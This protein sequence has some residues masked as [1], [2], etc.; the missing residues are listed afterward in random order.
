MRI[1][2]YQI[3]SPGCV[4]SLMLPP[5]AQILS[6]GV[7]SSAIHV[8]ILLDPDVPVTETRHFSI[9]GTGWDVNRGEL[10]DFVG[11]VHDGEFVWHVFAK[12]GEGQ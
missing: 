4:T 3:S 9:I 5:D 2:K 8:W 7:Q 1:H 11:T 6:V 12:R 10:G